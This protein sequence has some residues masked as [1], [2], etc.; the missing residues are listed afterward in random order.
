MGGFKLDI[1]GKAGERE[2]KINGLPGDIGMNTSSDKYTSEGPRM[3]LRNF[4]I[5]AKNEETPMEPLRVL[6]TK[7]DNMAA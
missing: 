2:R 6:K 5:E 4:R 1:S 7:S 3:K